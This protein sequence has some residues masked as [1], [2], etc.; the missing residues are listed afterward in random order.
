MN[1]N[2]NQHPDGHGVPAVTVREP[3]VTVPAAADV[4]P[5]T[6]IVHSALLAVMHATT[7]TLQLLGP[8]K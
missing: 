4:H 3:Y 5:P 6:E 1:F 2:I 7:V 8:L